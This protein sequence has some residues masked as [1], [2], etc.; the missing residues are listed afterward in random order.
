MKQQLQALVPPLDAITTDDERYMRE[1]IREAI[2]A[3]ERDEVPIGAVIV[4]DGH[5]IAR[6]YNQVEL[7]R[8][9][10]AHAEML[11]I[12]AAESALENWRLS[13]ATL[14]STIEPCAMCAGAILLSRLDRVVWGAPDIRVGANGSWI[15]LF[16]AQHP[17]HTVQIQGNVLL[18]WCQKPLKL[19]FQKRREENAESKRT[20]A[21]D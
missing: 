15:D 10:T 4:K 17:I 18:E 12:T 2:K 6:G 13:K 8:D 21:D 5:I 19:F 7:L 1:A 16:S 3:F 20:R 11:A 9:A 14:Y